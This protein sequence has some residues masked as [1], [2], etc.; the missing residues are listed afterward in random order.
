VG[1]HGREYSKV[2]HVKEYVS[3]MKGVQLDESAKVASLRQLRIL[4]TCDAD[5]VNLRK[6]SFTIV[7]I[8]RMI[9]SCGPCSCS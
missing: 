8:F 9:A 3:A 5:E 2:K 4:H 6:T 1:S 7:H